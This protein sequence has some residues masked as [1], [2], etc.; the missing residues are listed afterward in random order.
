MPEL[1]FFRHGEELLRVALGDRTAIGRAP[2]CD[3]TLPDPALSRVQAVVERRGDAFVLLDRS[4]HGTRVGGR[5][6]QEAPL[7]DGAELALGAW[8]ARFR[9][10]PPAE[11][12]ATLAAAGSTRIR[13]AES[14]GPLPPAARIR[15][16]ERSEERVESLTLDGVTVGKRGSA[17]LALDDPFVSSRHLRIEPREGR[18]LL[19][20]LGSTNGTWLGGARV[21]RAELPLGVPVSV[22]EAELVLEPLTAPPPARSA[23]FEGMLSADPAMG[24]VFELVDRVAP[25][26][27]AVAILGETGVGKELV[28]RALHARSERR[29]GPFIPVNCSAIAETLIESE[30]FGHE[31][32]AFSG[33]ERLRKGAFEEAHGGTL[34]L[35]EVGELPLDLQPKLLRVLELGEVKRVGSSRPVQC[36]VRIVAATHRDLRAAVRAGKFREDLFYRLCVVPITVPPLRARRGDVRAL[37]ELFL[38]ASAPR[39]L[40]LRWSEEALR[41][42]EGYDWPGNVRQLRNAVQRALLF[43][44]EGQAIAADAIV[45]EDTRSGAGAHGD[46]DT[47]YVRGLTME[48]IERE[49]I[50]LAL[51]RHSGRRAAVVRELKLAKSTIM[52][53]INQWSLQE[54]GR[55]PGEPPLEEEDGEETGEHAG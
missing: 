16:R 14:P 47:L 33:A 51:R 9:A 53:R 11:P 1:A 20:D 30:L 48:E 25:S 34:F 4:G 7:P 23:S 31:K 39:G 35:D 44:G 32:G 18:W 10:A 29:A 5:S 22:G 2:E 40:Q 55:S 28:A 45:F 19:V 38:R 13:A 54:E 15:V 50:R 49:A 43:R 26:T 36:D 37:A 42:L 52:K 17:D 8:R 27:A 41:R 46:D 21:E 24:Q 3:V 6:V 12:G